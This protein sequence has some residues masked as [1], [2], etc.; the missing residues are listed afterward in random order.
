VFLTYIQPSIEIGQL[1]IDE[2]VTTLTDLLLAAVSFFAYFSIRKLGKKGRIKWY[3]RYYFLFLGMGA[4]TG[5]LLGHAF[6]SRIAPGWKLLSWV[7]TVISVGF[8]IHAMVELVQPLVR[9]SVRKLITRINLL[10]MALA[11]FETVRT[12]SF[13]P[14]TFYSIFGMLVVVGSLSTYL[15][16][17]TGSKGV[18]R[19]LFGLG[20]G[21]IS[22]FIF[23][24]GWG[25]SP[26]LTHNDISHLI[27]AVS[28]FVIY[29]GVTLVIS[30]PDSWSPLQGTSA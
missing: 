7:F 17:K 18:V 29:K 25:I 2:P 13:A 4:L 14:T 24:Q 22:A 23:I 12:A 16:L 27:L 9:S 6:L 8:M 20:L 30:V 3:F 19:F 11:I 10:A 26:W 21:I 1:R 15:Y 5:G 28:T